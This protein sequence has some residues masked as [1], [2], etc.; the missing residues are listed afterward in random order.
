MGSKAAATK[1][2]IGRLRFPKSDNSV[3]CTRHTRFQSMSASRRPVVGHRLG[4]RFPLKSVVNRGL[5]GLRAG[6]V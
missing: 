1:A 4:D 5:P 6:G 3:I 2:K